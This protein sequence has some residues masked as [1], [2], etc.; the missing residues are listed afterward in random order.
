[1]NG[2][3][4]LS[5]I[6]QDNQRRI[7]WLLGEIDDDCLH[8]RP[9]PGANS[10]AITIW[11]CARVADVFFTQHIL[12]EPATAELW[13]IQSWTEKTGYDPYGIGLNGWGTLQGYSVAEVEAMPHFSREHLLR[14]S[15]AVIM[16]VSNHLQTLDETTLQATAPGYDGQQSVYFWIKAPMLDLTR[17][18]GEMLAIMATW[19]RQEVRE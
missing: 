15:D 1:M 12:N 13:S 17:H 3:D 5:D 18:V 7:H 4:I 8:W 11:H 14:Y 16:A 10:I 6:L 2:I 19:Q 9:D